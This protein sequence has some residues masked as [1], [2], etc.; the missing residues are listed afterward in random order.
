M[1]CRRN[2]GVPLSSVEY[3]SF[4]RSLQGVRCVGTLTNT[5]QHLSL[6][7]SHISTLS[8]QADSGQ[9]W[10]QPWE[11]KLKARGM[12]RGNREA[13]RGRRTKERQLPAPEGTKEQGA[14][15]PGMQGSLQCNELTAV[16]LRVN[17][18]REPFGVHPDQSL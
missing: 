11:C 15:S 2:K 10:S 1:F 17:K 5:C 18:E 13:D 3:A 14:V 9:E 7:S 8:V 12:M 4:A 16:Q 6:F